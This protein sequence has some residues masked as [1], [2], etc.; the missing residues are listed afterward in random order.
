MSSSDIT[1]AQALLSTKPTGGPELTKWFNDWVALG[2]AVR[3]VPNDDGTVIVESGG[4]EGHNDG[5]RRSSF[6]AKAHENP[7]E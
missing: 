6:S 5:E 7:G 1:A 3:G 4:H 2:A